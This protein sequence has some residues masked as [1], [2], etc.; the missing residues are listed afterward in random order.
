MLIR[1]IEPERD[2]AARVDG[3][4]ISPTPTM[5]VTATATAVTRQNVSLRRMRR[6]SR[7]ASESSD[8]AGS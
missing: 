7:I 2:S 1:A 5:A 6:R 3:A 8:M 4:A